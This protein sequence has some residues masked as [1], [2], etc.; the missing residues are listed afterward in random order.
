M[1]REEKSNDVGVVGVSEPPSTQQQQAHRDHARALRAAVHPVAG[2]VQREVGV[3]RDDG[4]EA[5]EIHDGVEKERL[6][7]Q[8]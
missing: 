1:T 4:E 6:H 3:R 7:R 5:S 8:T 2:A